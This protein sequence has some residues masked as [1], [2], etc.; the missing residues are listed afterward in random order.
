MEAVRVTTEPV[1]LVP[2]AAP[3][4]MPARPLHQGRMRDRPNPARRQLFW[5]AVLRRT[6]VFGLAAGTVALLARFTV[7]LLAADGSDTT[8]EAAAVTAFILCLAPIA[9]SFWIALAGFWS[10]SFGAAR[11]GLRPPSAQPAGF[12]RTALVV[13]LY[14]DDAADRFAALEAMMRDLAAQPGG[15][16]LYEVFVLS[17]TRSVEKAAIEAA[18]AG[19]LHDAVPSVPLWYRHRAENTGHK[20][21]NIANF[22]RTWGGRYDHLL[23]LDADSFMSGPTIRKLVALMEA[24][25][26][27]GLIQAP[28]RARRVETGFGFLL[29]FAMKV[30]GPL[31]EH[32]AAFINLGDGNYYGHN[33]IVRVDAFADQAGLPELSGRAPR[34]GLILSHDFV[35]AAFLRRAGWRVWMAPEL[36]G[37]FEEC[38]PNL[39][40]F[41]KRD[42]RWCQGNMQHLRIVSAAGLRPMSR[43]HL[44]W[45]ALAYCGAVLWLVF[46]LLGAGVIA[47]REFGSHEY[48]DANRRLFPIWPVFDLHQAT[49]LLVATVAL[50]LLPRVLAFLH[51]VMRSGAWQSPVR[52]GAALAVFVVEVVHSTLTAPVLMICYLRFVFAFVAGRAVSWSPK[53]SED[54]SLAPAACLS[55]FGVHAVVGMALAGIVAVTTPQLLGW[56]A[57]IWASLILAPAI[58][59][60]S[61]RPLPHRAG[62]PRPSAGARAQTV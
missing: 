53:E 6:I 55:A 62:L 14:N 28:V 38:P 49:L 21:G 47:E 52:T 31:F 17:D 54:G 23:V 15:P 44:G 51:Y 20:S 5:S 27:T 46:L 30:Y 35:E 16:D 9:I 11:P 29:G 12:S 32:G 58:T 34:G 37:S 22:C 13:T 48:F 10:L 45:G 60:L 25:P 3:R 50:L 18:F 1:A 36:D 57:P 8:L 61:A 39:I 59:W 2:P 41:A 19:R 26:D 24:N 40:A 42:R 56:T 7:E 33:A 43:F 4:P